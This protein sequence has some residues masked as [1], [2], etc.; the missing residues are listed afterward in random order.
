MTLAQT[1]P[2]DTT[3]FSALVMAAL[4]ATAAGCKQPRIMGADDASDSGSTDASARSD[5]PN[6]RTG[7]SQTS[8]S[9]G[10]GGNTGN[11]ASNGSGGA[12]STSNGSGGNTSNG[13]SSTDNSPADPVCSGGEHACAGMCVSNGDPRTC[14]TSCSP[15][16]QIP[17][18]TATCDGIHCGGSC[19]SGKT[20]SNGRCVEG[21]ASCD[22]QCPSG[23]HACAG[24]CPTKDNVTACG[25]SCSPC[26]LP[27]RADQA[28][29]DGTKCGFDCQ[30]GYH[31]CGD[32]CAKDSDATACGDSCVTC[33]TDP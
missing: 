13:A 27:S 2:L 10:S 21:T 5:G 28:T 7:D 3:L 22:G 17:D 6:A 29:C 31:R 1:S 33:P 25:A 18:G 20:L 15:C 26:P 16:D 11:D 23:T 9:P 32:H 19:P 4:A 30:T 24:T 14:G 8:S 12:T